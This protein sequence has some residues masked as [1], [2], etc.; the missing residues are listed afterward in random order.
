MI[1]LLFWLPNL[2][3]PA[4][5]VALQVAEGPTA[6][7]TIGFIVLAIIVGP[8]IMLIVAAMFGT[9]RTFRVPG[10]FVGSLILLIGAMIG[11]FA[12]S[13]VLLGFIVPQ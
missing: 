1:D 10:L 2:I 9:P 5:A 12:I 7:G 3:I 13:S 8:V 6:S 4:S 11:G